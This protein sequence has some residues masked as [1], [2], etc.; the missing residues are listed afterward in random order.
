MKKQFWNRKVKQNL[1]GNHH[2]K[3]RHTLVDKST[4]GEIEIEN[5]TDADKEK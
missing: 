4:K 5:K 3:E 2:K 1:E